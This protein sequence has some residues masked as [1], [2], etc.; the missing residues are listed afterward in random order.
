M[1]ISK[2]SLICT[3]DVVC[4]HCSTSTE[5]VNLHLC[6]RC[7]CTGISADCKLAEVPGGCRLDEW[8]Y[9][10]GLALLG[11]SVKSALL[12]ADECKGS[13]KHDRADGAAVT[14]P[15]Q[16]IYCSWNKSPALT[17]TRMTVDH[18]SNIL[19]SAYSGPC[20]AI[21][22]K[23]SKENAFQRSYWELPMAAARRQLWSPGQSH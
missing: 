17:L 12:A 23:K 15:R 3:A 16:V 4:T 8:T 5:I 11:G 19:M 10:V 7:D 2:P 14:E 1:L 9:I 22:V 6:S 18:V 21:L 13:T 20:K